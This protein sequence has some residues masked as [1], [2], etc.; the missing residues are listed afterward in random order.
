MDLLITAFKGI[1][2]QA[3][4][5][6]VRSRDRATESSHFSFPTLATVSCG[7]CGCSPFR[8]ISCVNLRPDIEMQK[9]LRFCSPRRNRVAIK[10]REQKLKGFRSVSRMRR[11]TRS[12]CCHD[13]N[14][15]SATHIDVT[16]RVVGRDEEIAVLAEPAILIHRPTAAADARRRRVCHDLQNGRRQAWHGV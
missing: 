2:Q 5:S 9:P 16:G 15:G 1:H 13:L 4:H 14:S 11:S 3:F 12:S 7:V 8:P 6:Y 10:G